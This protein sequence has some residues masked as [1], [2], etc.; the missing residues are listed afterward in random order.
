MRLQRRRFSEPSDVRTIPHGRIDVVD[1][2]DT[3][4]GRMTY[5]PGWRW[6]ID[7]QPIAGTDTC[8]YHHLGVTLSGR[9]R[10]QMADGT[11]LELGP[12]DVFEIPPG[13]DAW[14]IGDEPWVS[15]DFEAMRTYGRQGDARDE[16][17]LAT[18]V[19]TDIVDSTRSA[20]EFGAARWRDLVG[21]HNRKASAAIDRHRGRLVKTTGDGV[22]AQFDGAER[23][24]RGAAAIRE[25][26][27]GLGLE[28]RAGVH[29]GE[30]ELTAD[31]VRGIAV[32]TAARIMAVAE[33]GEILVSATVM[34]LL[35]GSGLTF[36]DA[37]IHELK[38][39]HG[40]RQL[41]RLEALEPSPK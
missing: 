28:I 3:V 30:V 7:V 33:S 16:R 27:H 40:A 32:H 8:Q 19:F 4:V 9:L 38:G 21:E 2:D 22:L 20:R 36:E 5:E 35:D 12:G 31:D 1:L 37:G 24:V 41:Y 13:H 14:V 10:A 23:A 11:E 34:D 39:L 17:I 6:S 15:V 25:A 29:T 18:M 26:A